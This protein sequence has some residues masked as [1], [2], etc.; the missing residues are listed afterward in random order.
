LLTI[1]STSSNRALQIGEGGGNSIPVKLTGF[2]ITA[3]TEVWAETGDVSA[4]A[5]FFVNLGKVRSP[6]QGTRTWESLEGD[7]RLS[8]TCS[9]L[10]AVTFQVQLRGLQ[11]AP[12]EWHVES[13]IESE[14]GQLEQLAKDAEELRN[15]SAAT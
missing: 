6:W 9:S 15:A 14:F 4:L 10:G 12:E 11:G 3:V 2:P 7:F 1:R 5:D 13:G 8:V